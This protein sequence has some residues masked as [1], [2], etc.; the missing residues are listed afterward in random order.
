VKGL[1]LKCELSRGRRGT[2]EGSRYLCVTG[3]VGGVRDLSLDLGCLDA[4]VGQ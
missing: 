3:L 4:A 1:N 2:E